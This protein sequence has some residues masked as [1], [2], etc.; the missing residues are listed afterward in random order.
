M[1]AALGADRFLREVEIAARLSH[2]H[3]LPL[4]DSVTQRDSSTY[5]MPYVESESLRARLHRRRR[6]ADRRSGADSARGSWTARLTAE[7]RAR[8]SWQH[9]DAPPEGILVESTHLVRLEVL[10]L[11]PRQAG[12]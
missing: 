12:A 11:T 3:I 5:V 8:S 2:P 4:Y 10:P 7:E 6:V 1:A 9:D